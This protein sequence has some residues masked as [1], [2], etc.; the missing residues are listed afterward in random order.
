MKAT[1][2]PEVAAEEVTPPPKAI[3]LEEAA[4][5]AVEV[6]AYCPLSRAISPRAAAAAAVAADSYRS[7]E[8]SKGT[9]EQPVPFLFF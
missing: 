5:A 9:G 3:R 4:V 1:S 8:F 2:R 7:M 6:A